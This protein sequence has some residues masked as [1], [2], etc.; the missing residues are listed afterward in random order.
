MTC[1]PSYP[2]VCIFPWPSD[3]DCE[4]IEFRNFKDIQPDKHGFDRDCDGIGCE[5]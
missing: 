3:L 5:S 2:D 1:D 4:E